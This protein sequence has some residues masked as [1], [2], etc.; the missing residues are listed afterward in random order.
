[1]TN[2]YVRLRPKTCLGEQAVKDVDWKTLRSWSIGDHQQE[3]MEWVKKTYS[4]LPIPGIRIHA[5]G[6]KGYKNRG[7]IERQ[8]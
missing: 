2:Q 7:G 3:E 6:Q 4:T 8:S 5:A 1:M